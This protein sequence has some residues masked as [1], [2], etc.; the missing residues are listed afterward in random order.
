MLFVID[1]WGHLFLMEWGSEYFL[2]L[3]ALLVDILMCLEKK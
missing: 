2:G 1:T 3:V